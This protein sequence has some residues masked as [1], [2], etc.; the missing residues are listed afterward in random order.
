MA[1][2]NVRRGAPIL[3]AARTVGTAPVA[4]AEGVET[5]TLVRGRIYS[6]RYKGET[7]EFIG[8]VE[9]VL[10]DKDGKPVPGLADA[11][12]E[13]HSE[14]RDSDGDAFEKPLFLVQRGTNRPS[15]EDTA[16]K[17][18]EIT[19]LPPKPLPRITR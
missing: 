2:Q 16:P 4:R 1:L 17:R 9:K 11:L 7:F 18:R 12:E 8:G 15:V 14:V 5:A 13:L 3:G 19:R 10:E 6:Y